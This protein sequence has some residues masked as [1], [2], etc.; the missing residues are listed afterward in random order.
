VNSV[1]ILE[2]LVAFPTVSRESNLELVDFARALLAES[3]V[4]CTLVPDATGRK[5]TA[6]VLGNQGADQRWERACNR[7]CWR[8]A[9]HHW[10]QGGGDGIGG[11]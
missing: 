1:A 3:G 10:A 9:R 2:R 4:A 6:L 8:F 7:D 11:K 5:A